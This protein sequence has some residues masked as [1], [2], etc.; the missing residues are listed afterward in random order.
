MPPHEQPPSGSQART[1]FLAIALCIVV[2]TAGLLFLIFVSF[3][4]FA[5]VPVVMAAMALF[6]GLHYLLWGR[7]FD[8]S[9]AEERAALAEDPPPQPGERRF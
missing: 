5:W 1:A 3:G 4:L 2:G 8:E 7:R 6:A 9:L